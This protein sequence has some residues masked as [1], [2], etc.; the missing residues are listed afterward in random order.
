MIKVIR[1]LVGLAIVV[2]W[3]YVGVGTVA[4]QDGGEGGD[5][6]SCDAGSCECNVSNTSCSCLTTGGANCSASCSS[7]GTSTCVGPKQE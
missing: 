5:S 3:G 1:T 6:A 2:T 7:G 4:A